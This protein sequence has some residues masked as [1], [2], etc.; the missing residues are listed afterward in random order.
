MIAMPK[1]T[2]LNPPIAT[3]LVD[4][5]DKD[6]DGDGVRKERGEWFGPTRRPLRQPI[7]RDASQEKREDARHDEQFRFTKVVFMI[8]PI[9]TGI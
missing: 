2:L 8:V 4:D 7:G 3:P 5:D 6:G 9:P 1:T